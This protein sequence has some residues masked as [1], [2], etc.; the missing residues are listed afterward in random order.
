MGCGKSTLIDDKSDKSDKS[1]TNDTLR[2]TISEWYKN[3][4]EVE[5]KF[6]PIGTWNVGS[7]TSMSNLFMNRSG[8]NEDIGCWDTSSVTTMSN[9]FHGAKNFNKPIGDWDTSKVTNMRDLFYAANN[10]NRENAHW[11][12][13]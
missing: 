11:Y 4:I 6:G 8:F 3:P 13:K 2:H 10:F 7:V 5:K 1:F 9:M 12:H